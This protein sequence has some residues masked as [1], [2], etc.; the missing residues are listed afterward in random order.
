MM[1]IKG[2]VTDPLKT[3]FVVNDIDIVSNKK[4]IEKN[5]PIKA[6]FSFWGPL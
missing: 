6:L 1:N 4:F 3:G 2:A 5:L